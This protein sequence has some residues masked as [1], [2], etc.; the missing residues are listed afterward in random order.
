L[1]HHLNAIDGVLDGVFVAPDADDGD[2]VHRLI[3]F[4]VAPGLDADAIMAALRCR[5]DAAFLPRP[6]HLVAALPRNT[7]GKLPREEVMRLLAESRG[8]IGRVT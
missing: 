2:A 7:L 5:I 3:A 8:A 6:L 1:N 4:A